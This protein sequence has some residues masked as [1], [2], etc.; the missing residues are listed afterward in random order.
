MGMI[1]VILIM[2]FNDTGKVHNALWGWA[3][4]ED[5]DDNQPSTTSDFHSNPIDITTT[6]TTT[7]PPVPSPSSPNSL[8]IPVI[9]DPNNPQEG[10][11]NSV[12]EG[13]T[14]EPPGKENEFMPTPETTPAPETTIS[15]TS[16]ST[17]AAAATTTSTAAARGLAGGA[18]AVVISDGGSTVNTGD[19]GKGDPQPSC[20]MFLGKGEHGI[21]SAEHEKA[22]DRNTLPIPFG[23]DR[24]LEAVIDC[25]QR[26]C[27]PLPDLVELFAFPL[28]FN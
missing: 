28:F 17:T 25:Y 6:T 26:T 12:W 15:T 2:T 5:N 10:G 11:E 22:K 8:P 3:D 27:D 19:L 20:E 9:I 14:P 18:P 4:T 13:P 21:C 1:A 7:L 24:P 16:T 23:Y